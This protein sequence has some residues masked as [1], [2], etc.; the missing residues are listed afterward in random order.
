VGD[1]ME[2]RDGAPQSDETPTPSHIIWALEKSPR[3]SGRMRAAELTKID[4]IYS[5]ATAAAREGFCKLLEHLY[6][7]NNMQCMYRV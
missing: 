1:I 7:N 2:F 3:K 5:V 6:N 4:E